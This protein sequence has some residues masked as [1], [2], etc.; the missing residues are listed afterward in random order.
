MDW[1]IRDAS[2]AGPRSGETLLSDNTASWQG[3]RKDSFIERMGENTSFQGR[4]SS[5]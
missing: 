3:L 4:E 2:T 1:G 5:N